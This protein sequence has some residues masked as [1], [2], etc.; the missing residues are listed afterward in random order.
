MVRSA[1]FRR[2]AFSLEK[3]IS[4]G[5]ESGL[6]G[7]R[8][9]SCAPAA[10]GT[11]GRRFMAGQVVHDDDVAGRELGHG[12]A[13]DVGQEG[14]TIHWPVEHLRC[15]HA[16]AAQTRDEAGGFPVPVRHPVVCRLALCRSDVPCS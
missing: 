1:A 2:C 9:R 8:N 11:H 7:E 4:I 5:L 14:F 13:G 3:A 16:G 15:D 12:D 6:Y 10:G